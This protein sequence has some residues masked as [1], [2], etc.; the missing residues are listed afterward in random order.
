MKAS[1]NRKGFDELPH[2]NSFYR[3]VFVTVFNTMDKTEL[4]VVIRINELN[5]VTQE[6]LENTLDILCTLENDEIPVKLSIEENLMYY[7][8]IYFQREI[9]KTEFTREK[10]EE[11]KR[12]KGSINMSFSTYKKALNGVHTKLLNHL[13]LRMNNYPPFEERKK[14]LDNH[15][16]VN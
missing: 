8:V 14:L 2:M 15:F 16:V 3:R 1:D 4:P 10:F 13:A 7:T 5:L 6:E 9:D 12:R 11:D